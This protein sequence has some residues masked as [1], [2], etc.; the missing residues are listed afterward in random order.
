[1]PGARWRPWQSGSS[2]SVRAA[3]VVLVGPGRKTKIG[4]GCLLKSLH[5]SELT[6]RPR[7]V[8]LFYADDVPPEEYTPEVLDGLCPPASRHLIEVRVPATL[9]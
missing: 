4:L 9:P 6:A 1:M 5:F 8:L 2:S 3:F 7:P